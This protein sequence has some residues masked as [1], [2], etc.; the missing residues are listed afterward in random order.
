[1]FFFLKY[2]KNAPPVQL[3]AGRPVVAEPNV[4]Y[5]SPELQQ[6]AIISL[7]TG[8]LYLLGD[9]I[10]SSEQDIIIRK[11]NKESTLNEVFLYEHIKGHYYWFLL[12]ET[13]LQCGTSFGSIFPVYYSENGADVLVSS[14]SLYLAEQLNTLTP[15]RRNLL[16]RLLFNYPFFNSTW[17]QEIQLL[18]AH[19]HLR[20]SPA[21]LRVE[22]SFQISDYFGTPQV[23]TSRSLEDLATL[24][25][26]ETRSFYPAEPFAISLTG[27][28]D[29]R[30]LVAAATKDRRDF[31]TYSFGV[32]D[33]SDVQLPQQQANR[34]NIPYTPIFLDENYLE[35]HALQAARTFLQLT[36]YNGNLG[37]PH[38]AYA[39][40]QLSKRTKYILTGNFGSELFR[41][42]H[43][44][45]VM[46]T[47]GLI[48]LFAASDASWKDFL[49]TETKQ[50][51]PADFQSELDAL[52]ADLEAYLA[53]MQSWDANHKFYYF[54][55]NEIF[56][57]Y[58]GAELVMQSH[59]LNNRTPY[60][61]FAFFKALNQ[62]GWAGV[63][64]RLF[65]K[66]KTKRMKG[67]L[68]YATLIRQ[69]DRRFYHLNTNKGYS[70]ADVLEHARLPLL[71]AKVIAHKYLRP[72][73]GDN[74]AVNAFFQA[75]YNQLAS[76]VS[77]D[78]F[79]VSN[80]STEIDRG[81]C[82][83]RWIKW[84]SIAYGWQLTSQQPTPILP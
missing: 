66:D 54:V 70:P 19:R 71:A 30:T 41:A 64:A 1:M 35:N 10:F 58:F 72:P 3:Q 7:K 69:T 44:P 81:Q 68:F 65:E 73:E 80:S 43:L 8:T 13:G 9:P 34:L 6:L 28:F 77:P 63:H 25:Q 42:L 27:G 21:G 56:R 32:P 23:Q 60:L 79:E 50:F 52:I 46:M 74:N 78:L 76:S 84:Y 55:W 75:H 16:E 49:Q 31:F 5:T 15:N 12:T 14:A 36:E 24:F 29:G 62:T 20:L 67:Q 11:V 33:S 2:D 37:R 61:N 45:G 40:Q 53:P 17:W 39:A 83:E 4:L 22:G 51:Q 38:Y 82:L 57:K 26:T 47:E 59:F 48:R 18:P